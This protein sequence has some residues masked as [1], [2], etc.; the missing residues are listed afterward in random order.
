M[1]K[2]THLSDTTRQAEMVLRSTSG[3][4]AVIAALALAV[5]H[6]GSSQGQIFLSYQVSGVLLSLIGFTLTFEPHFPEYW[7]IEATLFFS[8]ALLISGGMALA[9]ESLVP[10]MALIVAI[11]M[12]TVLL[13]WNWQF[14]LGIGSLCIVSAVLSSRD[15]AAAVHGYG[16]LWIPVA[17]ECVIAVLAAVQLERQR[18]QQQAYFEALAA[19]EE[20]F[21]SLIENAPDGLTVVNTSGNIVFQSSSAK[22]LLGCEADEMLHRSA[23]EFIDHEAAPQLRTLLNKCLKLPEH[24]ESVT[25]RCRHTDGSWRTI[26]AVA[27]QLSNYGSEALVVFNWRNVTERVTRELQLRE[28]EERFRSIFQHS[29]NAISISSRSDGRYID[30][31]DEWLKVFGYTRSE[32]IG[33]NPLLLKLWMDSDDYVRFATEFLTRGTIHNRETE[34]RAKDGATVVGRLSVVTIETSGNQL[35]LGIV[36]VLS[37]VRNHPFQ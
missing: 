24:S 9:I 14:Q 30:V 31:N 10:L 19:D 35:A 11:P 16:L 8:L 17:A 15:A 5:M 32:A 36:N 21:R 20:Q 12:V 22:R 25:I 6:F 18:K 7:H 1:K 23:F 3:T 29:T 13:P 33:K 4:L 37:R 26:E 2:D 28:S 27:K 34:F